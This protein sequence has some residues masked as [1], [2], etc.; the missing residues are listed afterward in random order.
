M[1]KYLVYAFLL[2]T[3]L[4]AGMLTSCKEDEPKDLIVGSWEEAGSGKI[5]TF[6]E[7]GTSSI[8][9]VSGTWS[10]AGNNLTLNTPAELSRT[11]TIFTISEKSMVLIYPEDPTVK[12]S[13]TKK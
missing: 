3:M 13:Y 7:N 9:G 4:S 1:K 6:N 11:I 2:I 8:S 10:V 12:V 5:L